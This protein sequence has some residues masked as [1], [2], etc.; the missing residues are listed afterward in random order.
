[1]VQLPY[2]NVYIKEFRKRNPILLEGLTCGSVRQKAGIPCTS[3][4]KV[5]TNGSMSGTG[6]AS[7]LSSTARAQWRPLV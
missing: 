5:N 7:A 6:T 1:M 4:R 3:G 2:Q